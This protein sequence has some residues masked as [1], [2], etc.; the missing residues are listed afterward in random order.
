MN[1]A[2]G[3]DKGELIPYTVSQATEPQLTTRRGGGPTKPPS[4]GPLQGGP[5]IIGASSPLT[6]SSDASP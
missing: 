2:S 3:V 1:P 6:P 4:L 5:T